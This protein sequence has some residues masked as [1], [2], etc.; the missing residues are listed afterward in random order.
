LT[1]FRIGSVPYASLVVRVTPVTTSNALHTNTHA[2]AEH[3]LESCICGLD[4]RTIV[5]HI[6]KFL[7]RVT[8]RETKSSSVELFVPAHRGVVRGSCGSGRNDA[9][10]RRSEP[11]QDCYDKPH[12]ES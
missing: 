9:Q 10:V 8:F 6:Q 5:D 2:I 4:A 11:N 12:G 1:G 3:I 7:G